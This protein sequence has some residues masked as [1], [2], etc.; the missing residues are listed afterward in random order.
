MVMCF[1][2]NSYQVK[3]YTTQL[4]PGIYYS[5]TGRTENP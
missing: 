1:V 3:Q 2:F 4:Q 5:V